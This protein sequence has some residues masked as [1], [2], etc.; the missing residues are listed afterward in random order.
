MLDVV[1]GTSRAVEWRTPAVP[2]RR[3]AVWLQVTMQD[4]YLDAIKMVQQLSVHLRLNGLNH[5]STPNRA[6]LFVCESQHASGTPALRCASYAAR[7]LLS[8]RAQSIQLRLYA[9]RCLH[10]SFACNLT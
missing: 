2:Q 6:C 5:V 7:V 10:S 9:A 3:I 1:F 4:V 8:A